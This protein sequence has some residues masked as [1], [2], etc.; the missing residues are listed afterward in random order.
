M[1]LGGE[2]WMRDEFPEKYECD[3]FHPYTTTW[4]CK[5]CNG[6]PQAH[7]SFMKAHE[8]KQKKKEMAEKTSEYEKKRKKLIEL[9]G[10]EIDSPEETVDIGGVRMPLWIKGATSDPYRTNGAPGSIV[11]GHLRHDCWYGSGSG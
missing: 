1:S 8:E 4:L 10:T 11:F 3:S 2:G 9:S 5:A 7:K 6:P